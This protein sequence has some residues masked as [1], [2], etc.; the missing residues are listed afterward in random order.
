MTRATPISDTLFPP[1]E[2]IIAMATDAERAGLILRLPDAIVHEKIAELCEACV[3]VGF[4]VGAAFL[5]ARAA[6]FSSARRIDGGLALDVMAHLEDLRHA[7]MV[8]AFA[9]AISP[10]KVSSPTG[11]TNRAS[12][13]ARPAASFSGG[14]GMTDLSMKKI[15]KTAGRIEDRAELIGE[16]EFPIEMTEVG[17]QFVIPGCERPTD[18]DA[19]DGGKA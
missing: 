4:T 11:R 17:P 15:G 7:M 1:A 12:R 13:A 16:F 19:T 5:T 8:I 6:S 3:A 18:A 2:Q 10:Q 9:C 14:G